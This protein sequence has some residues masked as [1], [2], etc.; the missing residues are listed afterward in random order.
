MTAKKEQKKVLKNFKFSPEIVQRL[1]ES[2]NRTGESMTALLEAAVDKYLPSVEE[3]VATACE[4][5]VKAIRDEFAARKV[6]TT[7]F[8]AAQSGLKNSQSGGSKK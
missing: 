3:D 1:T 7:I 6:R 2:A 8:H 5:R 4:K